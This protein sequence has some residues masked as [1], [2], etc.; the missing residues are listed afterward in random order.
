[1]PAPK[2]LGLL[3]IETC[4]I[5]T[6]RDC[7]RI[8]LS[9]WTTHIAKLRPLA[10]CCGVIAFSGGAQ[11]EVAPQ[12][13]NTLG[14]VITASDS[15][16]YKT[17]FWDE[18]SDGATIGAAELWWSNLSKAAKKKLGGM[19]DLVTLHVDIPQR[20]PNHEDI[21][22]QPTLFKDPPQRLAGGPISYGMNLDDTVDGRATTKTC[23]HEKFASNPDG[24]KNIDNQLY[25]VIGC[26]AGF[27]ELDFIDGYASQERKTSGR[28]LILIEVTGVDDPKND[29][30]VRVTFYRA[31]GQMPQDSRRRVLPFGSYVID[32][33]ANGVPR[34][35]ASA[36]GKIVNGVLITEPVDATLPSYGQTSYFVM[37]I[38]D[39][40]LKLAIA[41]DGKTAKGTLAGYYDLDRWIHYMT[42]IEYLMVLGTLNCPSVYEAVHRLADGYP[43]PKTGQ[44]TAISSAFNIEAAAA[45]VVH[46]P[47]E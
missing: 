32:T 36:R 6:A 24:E 26:S 37:G 34:Y 30:D 35:G 31:V 12:A 3:K 23:K 45:F 21:C 43:D 9:K 8:C 5:E 44:C 18:C 40:R 22:W 39:M 1:M 13:A 20:G 42:N 47:V 7:L 29:D 17:K 11:A 33:D 41:A 25:R 46:P 4:G 28:G 16:I 19:Q 38:R 2:S 15:G 27:R 10:I 14:F